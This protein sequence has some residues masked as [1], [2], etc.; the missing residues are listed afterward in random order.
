MF[1]AVLAMQETSLNI[2]GGWPVI[3]MFRIFWTHTLLFAGANVLFVRTVAICQALLSVKY[4]C[5]T[6]CDR[7]AVFAICCLFRHSLSSPWLSQCDTGQVIAVQFALLQPF[8]ARFT[9]CSICVLVAYGSVLKFTFF[10]RSCGAPWSCGRP[11]ERMCSACAV[12][13]HNHR[14]DIGKPHKESGVE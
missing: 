10:G 2:D 8:H 3:F 1:S 5:V 11:N 12:D 14:P 9:Y 13:S 4:A 7:I 6:V